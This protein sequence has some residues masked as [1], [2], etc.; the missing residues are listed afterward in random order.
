MN[1][2]TFGWVDVVGGYEAGRATLIGPGPL[3]SGKAMIWILPWAVAE[4][5]RLDGESAGV[6]PPMA[7]NLNEGERKSICGLYAAVTGT[8]VKD[9]KSWYISGS[10]DPDTTLAAYAVSRAAS[11]GRGFARS[12]LTAPLPNPDAREDNWTHPLAC[13]LWTVRFDRKRYGLRQAS[14]IPSIDGHLGD[15]A[16]I[17]WLARHPDPALWHRMAERGALNYDL[18]AVRDTLSWIVAQPECDR[19]TAAGIFLSLQGRDVVGLPLAAL[20]KSDTAYLLAA[21][22]LLRSEGSGYALSRFSLSS[23]GFGNDQSGLLADLRSRPKLAAGLPV[24]ERLL[25]QT[26]GGKAPETA[27]TIHSESWISRA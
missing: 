8:T 25:G 26:F 19:A 17:K 2:P 20:R 22:I 21:K 3:G 27:T 1:K 23:I 5:R 6:E 14:A 7:S 16:V 24:P 12:D 4:A 11:A 13:A 18:P 15:P 9:G 10:G